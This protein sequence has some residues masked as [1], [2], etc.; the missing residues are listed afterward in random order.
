MTPLVLTRF[1]T[2][3]ALGRGLEALFEM[4]RSGRS[5]LRPCTFE[6]RFPC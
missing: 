4:L 1:T 5:G 2:V 3:N 6:R